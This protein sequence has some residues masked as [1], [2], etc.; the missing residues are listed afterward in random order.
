MLKTT[1]N[2]TSKLG[3][4]TKV[5]KYSNIITL[6]YLFHKKWIWI[7]FFYFW[8]TFVWLF[9]HCR[10]SSCL[11]NRRVDG[12]LNKLDENWG[13]GQETYIFR[14]LIWDTSIWKLYQTRRTWDMK[15]R[16]GCEKTT[17]KKLYGFS[18]FLSKTSC[19]Y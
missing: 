1:K 7:V 4:N 2:S 18:L 16:R 5:R 8:G 6:K 14:L 17:W 3:S 9:V 13:S 15:K 10:V 12:A 11:Q 19:G